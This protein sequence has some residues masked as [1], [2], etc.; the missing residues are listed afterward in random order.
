MHRS[1]LGELLVGDL[2]R[3]DLARGAL[4]PR[5][6][7]DDAHERETAPTTRGSRR[8]RRRVV[9]RGLDAD[10]VGLVGL[11][12]HLRGGRSQLRSFSHGTLPKLNSDASGFLFI[13]PCADELLHQGSVGLWCRDSRKQRILTK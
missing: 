3:G 6:A 7:H 9:G 13:R 1:E 11:A 2:E 12:H 8:S 5:D 4:T 10:L